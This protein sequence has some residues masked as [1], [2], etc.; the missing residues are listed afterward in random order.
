[1]DVSICISLFH[2]DSQTRVSMPNLAELKQ[3]DCFEDLGTIFCPIIAYG[4]ETFKT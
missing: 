2:V 3:T 1:M 4:R